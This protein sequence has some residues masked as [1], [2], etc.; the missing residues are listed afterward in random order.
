MEELLHMIIKH[1]S[2]TTIA[3]TTAALICF[4]VVRSYADATGG[5]I[6]RAEFIAAHRGQQFVATVQLIKNNK[7]TIP[8]EINAIMA[9]ALSNDMSFEEQMTLLELANVIAAM[10]IHWNNGDAA[11][12]TKVE[13]ALD[14]VLKKEEERKAYADRWISYEKLPGSFVMTNNEAAITSAGLSPVVF[15]HWRHNFYY[16]CKACHDKPFKMQRNEAQITQKAITQ[17]AFCG[18]CHNG[19]QAFSADEECER[20]HAAGLLGSERVNDTAT[21]KLSAIE[22]T[23]KRLGSSWD[24]SRLT[25]GRLPLDKF[26]GIDWSKLRDNGVYAPITGADDITV[27]EA[28]SRLIVFNSKV[29]DIKN[30]VF[31]HAR[32]SEQAQCASCHQAVFKDTL[33]A[34]KVSMNA[35]ASGMYCGACHG[36]AAFK[37]ADCNRCHNISPDRRPAGARLRQ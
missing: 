20:C 7:E 37:L 26:G 2:R 24:S 8:S 11:L 36:K 31:D 4:A 1:R 33:G 29:S 22:E 23:A 10:H 28:Q 34:N 12:L 9:E 18:Q 13:Q 35:L 14:T 6:F 32:H 27:S 3:V 21:I 19:K 30:V 17:G 25:D 15:T 16:A 5:S